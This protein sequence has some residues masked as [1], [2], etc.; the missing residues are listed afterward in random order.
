MANS[1]GS[2]GSNAEAGTQHCSPATSMQ[3]TTVNWWKPILLA[4]KSMHSRASAPPPTRISRPSI[5]ADCE[6]LNTTRRASSTPMAPRPKISTLPRPKCRDGTK[7]IKTLSTAKPSANDGRM[8][9]SVLRMSSRE[10]CW[11]MP[12]ALMLST[13]TSAKIVDDR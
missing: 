4:A 6:D 12:S 11:Y 9:N 13:M 3:P 7:R 8:R 5:S 1:D 2:A 10:R